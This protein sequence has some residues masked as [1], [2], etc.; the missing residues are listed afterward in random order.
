MIKRPAGTWR[1]AAGHDQSGHRLRSLGSRPQ[2]LH[3]GVLPSEDRFGRACPQC[4]ARAGHGVGAS[5]CRRFYRA[6]RLVGTAASS[7]RIALALLLLS[8]P[9]PLQAG[10]D[11]TA[12]GQ[13]DKTRLPA[14]FWIFAAFALLYGDLRNDERQLGPT[15]QPSQSLGAT[16]AAASFAQ[17]RPSGHG[18][19]GAGLVC[20]Y[21]KTVPAHR[22]LPSLAVRDRDRFCGHRT[23][24]RWQLPRSG[25]LAFGLTGLGCSALLPLTISFGQEDMKVIAASVAGGLIAFYQMGYGIAAFGVGPLEGLRRSQPWI[26]SSVLQR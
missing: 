12:K 6:R 11:K 20:R 26:H 4:A 14:R 7:G 17:E 16:P 24:A 15:L 3:G 1:A 9:L 18:D 22:Y 5:V 25:I 10:T 23:S 21:R 2:H 8:L 19:T 13:K